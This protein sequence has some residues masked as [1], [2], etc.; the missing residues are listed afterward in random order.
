MKF[1]YERKTETDFIGLKLH[2]LP[3]M[4]FDWPIHVSYYC[5]GNLEVPGEDIV[6]VDTNW[7]AEKT[8]NERGSV[9]G[10]HCTMDDKIV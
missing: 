1:F 7:K 10:V 3:R 5:Q 4:Y 8:M 6:V 2:K 9:V